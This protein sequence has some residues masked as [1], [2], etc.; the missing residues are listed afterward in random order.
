M[1]S[2]PCVCFMVFNRYKSSLLIL[3]PSFFAC[4][5]ITEMAFFRLLQTEIQSLLPWL[6]QLSQVKTTNFV[7]LFPSYFKVLRLHWFKIKKINYYKI[8]DGNTVNPSE[9]NQSMNFLNRVF[10]NGVLKVNKNSRVLRSPRSPTL[11]CLV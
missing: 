11:A 1:P 10:I 9:C 2:Y 6:C 4:C 7:I 8:L 5:F 3:L